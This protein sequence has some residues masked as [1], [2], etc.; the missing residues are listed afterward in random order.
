MLTFN[1]VVLEQFCSF[2]I[3]FLVENDVT[4]Q[5]E[6]ELPEQDCLTQQVFIIRVAGAKNDE[7]RDNIP[8]WLQIL[9][10]KQGYIDIFTAM[11]LS[12]SLK[13]GVDKCL[14]FLLSII[15]RKVSHKTVAQRR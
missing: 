3:I 1:E 4:F 15:V 12:L 2:L 9:H 5:S 11:I 10:L 8:V 7:N 6:H 14:F 13:V